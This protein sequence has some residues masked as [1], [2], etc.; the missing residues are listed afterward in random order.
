MA[1]Q[2]NCGGLMFDESTL[3]VNPITKKL[4]VSNG[5]QTLSIIADMMVR[6]YGVDSYAKLVTALADTTLG[7]AYALADITL[8]G[9]LALAHAIELNGQD[10]SLVDDTL[11]ATQYMASQISASGVTV[12]NTVFEIS[13]NSDGN[14]LYSI[15]VYSPNSTITDNTFVMA[16]AGSSGAV[17]VY[18]EGYTG[19]ILSDNTFSNGVAF[20]GGCVMDEVSNNTF[21]A[22]K[23]FGL[24]ECTIGGIHY[25]EADPSKVLAIKN[26]LIAQGNTTTGGTL[27]VEG[28]FES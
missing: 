12:K 23:G 22:T 3:E 27:V 6:V 21:S 8:T 10:F 15:D 5:I 1:T 11:D 28:Y 20:T 4:G 13:G 14:A 25:F 16:N 18:Y 24:G 26:Y 17:S 19:H 7:Y 9:Q 2:T